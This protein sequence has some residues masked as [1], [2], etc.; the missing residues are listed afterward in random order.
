[1]FCSECGHAAVQNARFCANCGHP[2]NNYIPTENIAPAPVQALTAACYLREGLVQRYPTVL[3]LDPASCAFINI[4]DARLQSITA[5]ASYI[6]SYI[7]REK[8]KA[9]AFHQYAQS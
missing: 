3:W 9:Q 8:A 7:Q 1:M 4:G 5:G 2:L 6:P